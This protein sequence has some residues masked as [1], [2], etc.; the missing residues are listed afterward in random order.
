MQKK[1]SIITVT[2]IVLLVITAILAITTGSVAISV[3]E[4]YQSLLYKTGLSPVSSTFKVDAIIWGIR[5]PRVLMSLAVGGVMGICGAAMQGLFRNPLADPSIIGISAGA[6]LAAAFVIVLGGTVLAAYGIYVQISA[7]SLA[8]FLGAVLATGLIFTLSVSQGK[9]IVS[10]ML[11]TGIAINAFSMAFV[12]LLTYLS[13]DI[14]LRTLTFWTLGSLGGA[15]WKGTTLMCI[16]FLI[17]FFGLR[18][19]YKS[20]NLLALGESEARYLGISTESLK[21]R[22]LIFT[23]LGVGVSVAL[24]GMISF[25]GLVVPHLVRLSGSSD[26]RFV[27]PVSAIGG[28]LLLCAG[29]LLSRVLAPPTEVPIGVI[30]ALIGSPFFLF[31]LHQQKKKNLAI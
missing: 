5:L 26:N 2:L 30:T 21:R 1:L 15:N 6:S 23:A 13:S 11:L 7:L 31:L 18:S 25:V 12:G 14:Q 3:A 17:V 20:L 29:D 8:T 16:V 28:A 22:V 9:A 4:L 27:L 10:S 19:Q 24:C